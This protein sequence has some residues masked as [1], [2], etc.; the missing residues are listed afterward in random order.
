MPI[1]A[2]GVD[3]VRIDRIAA[4]RQRHADRFLERCF[5]PAERAYALSSDRLCDERLA[6]R[7]AAKEAVFKA[8]GTGW[9]EGVGWAEVEVTRDA[10]TGRPGIAL[11]G[12][13]AEVAAGLGIARWHLSLSHTEGLALAGVVAESLG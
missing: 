2:T 11:T 8:L 6:A 4:S 12:R 9:G 5:T 7:F 1:V 13:A 10:A 3:L